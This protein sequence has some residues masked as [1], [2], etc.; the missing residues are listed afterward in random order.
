MIIYFVIST[1]LILLTIITIS[2]MSE[3]N[4]VIGTFTIII[5]GMFWVFLS[6]LPTMVYTEKT[7]V[8]YVKS[9]HATLSNYKEVINTENYTLLVT[10]AYMVDKIRKDEFAV[11]KHIH[12]NTF[13]NESIPP[14]IL[15]SPNF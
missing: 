12:K 11:E 9:I 7:E 15:H 1:V 3:T 10:D 13:N 8:T 6:L 5:G 2:I 14:N 4:I